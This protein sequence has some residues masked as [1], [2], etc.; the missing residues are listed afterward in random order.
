MNN[1]ARI[2]G[3]FWGGRRITFKTVAGAI[4]LLG[5]VSLSYL[6]GAST[7]FFGL[8]SSDYLSKAFMGTADY[9]AEEA[10]HETPGGAV[11]QAAG[12]GAAAPYDGFTLVLTSEEA[13]AWLLDLNGDV[14]HRWRM[15]AR[16]P[17]PRAPH[18]REPE[19][20]LPIRWDQAHVYPNGDLLVLCGG[21]NIGPYGYG[22]A[23][24]N[25]DSR[26]LWGYSANVHHDFC[27]ADD[28]RIYLLTQRPDA[29][30]PEELRL[31]PGGYAAE[32]LGVL[33]PEGRELDV[34]P[35]YEALRDSPH[36]LQFLAGL[37]QGQPPGAGPGGGP[38]P[39]GAPW[40]P[41][42]PPPGPFPAPPP[43]VTARQPGDVLHS[44]SV[45]VLGREL[46]PK[47]PLFPP[48]MVLLSLRT[49]SLLVG[50]DPRK[51]AVVWAARGPWQGQ[52]DAHFLDNGHL[53][54][55]DNLGSPQGARVLEY[56]P[57][58]QGVPWACAGEKGVPMVAPVKGGTQRLPNGNTLIIDPGKGLLEV[59]QSQEVV[60]RYS[61]PARPA[62]PV[63]PV[64]PGAP[65]APP[66]DLIGITAA[67]RCG[68]GELTFLPKKS[69]R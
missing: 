29:K 34:I 4:S 54:L 40:P 41:P 14:V 67:W 43:A 19:P 17:W 68:T 52:H 38:L 24:L 46:A 20:E 44:N 65:V 51:R 56:D 27:V 16:R 60:W 8:P 48:G 63:A 61:L 30:P 62:P 39:P 23:K 11:T 10:P 3:G 28:G 49:P 59:T 18:V 31:P 36:Y 12:G 45:K 6:S 37:E 42:G 33:S 57:T 50:L 5:L 2:C 47:F 21:G 22:L 26:L 7:M 32:E 66:A 35:L 53:L 69:A 9:F 55:F 25:K 15:P 13:Q 58:T 64:A 1:F